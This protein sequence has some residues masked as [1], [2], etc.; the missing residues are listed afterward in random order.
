[1]EKQTVACEV[2]N[3]FLNISLVLASKW[4]SSF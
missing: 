4:N 1:M 3:E 2:R